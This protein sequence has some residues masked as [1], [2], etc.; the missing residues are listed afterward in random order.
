MS[1]FEAVD[2]RVVRGNPT[3]AELAAVTAVLAAAIEEETAER[4]RSANERRSAWELT[5]R[6]LRTPLGQT[7]W[8]S[9]SG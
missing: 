3:P 5:Q 8:R 2:F 1:E 7:G 6:S 9:F 4:E